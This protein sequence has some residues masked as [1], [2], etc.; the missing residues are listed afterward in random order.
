MGLEAFDIAPN[1]NGGRKKKTEEKRTVNYEDAFVLEDDSEEFWRQLLNK[2]SITGKPEGEEMV[3]LCVE[4]HILPRTIESK[5]HKHEIFEYEWMKSQKMREKGFD[6]EDK[7]S[8][9]VSFVA[10]AKE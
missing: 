3:E 6:P 7:D 4:L 10:D 1:N 2:H 5:L 8:A 9:L